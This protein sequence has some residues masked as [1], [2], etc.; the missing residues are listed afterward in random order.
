MLASFQV[1]LEELGKSLASLVVTIDYEAIPGEE[2][3]RDNPASSPQADLIRVRVDAFESWD[4]YRYDRSIDKIEWFRML[5]EIA[6][7]IIDK[8]WSDIYQTMALEDAADREETAREAAW[9]SKMDM[10]REE[11]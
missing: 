5:D 9:E 4:D 8:H 10:L 3:T 2:A 6:L 7:R 11:G 1:D